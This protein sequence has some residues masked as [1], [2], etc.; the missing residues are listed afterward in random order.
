MI[1]KLYVL[2]SRWIS[3]LGGQ[4]VSNTLMNT[5]IDRTG[6]RQV[7]KCCS[8]FRV[9][10]CV[11]VW[12]SVLQCGAVCCSVVQ[13]VAVWCSV[14]R[15]LISV[16]IA[17][18][19]GRYSRTSSYIRVAVFSDCCGVLQCDAVRCSVLQCRVL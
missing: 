4:L 11:A 17:Q 19:Q 8:V 14:L 10:Q 13:C 9:L 3:C 16:L 5:R 2:G 1:L 6:A 12:C 7:F 15:V 18:E